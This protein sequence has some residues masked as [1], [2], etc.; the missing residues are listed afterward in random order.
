MAAGG[1]CG[2]FRII[3]GSP[4]SG[5]AR[6]TKR[7]WSDRTDEALQHTGLLPLEVRRRGCKPRT[8]LPEVEG[9]PHHGGK[10]WWPA[11]AADPVRPSQSDP[12]GNTALRVKWMKGR[13]GRMWTVLACNR[14]HAH[15]PPEAWARH[16]PERPRV[17]YRSGHV[18]DEAGQHSAGPFGAQARTWTGC[19]TAIRCG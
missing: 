11:D 5:I 10:R 6:T 14:P 9:D 3:G 12:P 15:C 8:E 4:V 19:G 1:F 18:V 7:Y 16:R 17:A 2:S 13:L